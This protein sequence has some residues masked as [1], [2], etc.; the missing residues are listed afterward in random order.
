MLTN[1]YEY[2][3][4]NQSTFHIGKSQILSPFAKTA[5]LAIA[6]IVFSLKFDFS[7]KSLDLKRKQ[8][9]PV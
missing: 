5:Y 1:V 3:D 4:I 2:N 9:K 6:R 7:I 8:W